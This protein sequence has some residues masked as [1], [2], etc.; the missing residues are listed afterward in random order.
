MRLIGTYALSIAVCLRRAVTVDEP[1]NAL[2][3]SM[4][5]NTRAVLTRPKP[6][7]QPFRWSL[8]RRRSTMT[9]PTRFSQDL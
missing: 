4:S 5:L 9:V 1:K 8:G 7:C 3:C 2:R 6:S